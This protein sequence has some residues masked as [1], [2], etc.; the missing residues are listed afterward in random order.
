M[1][2]Q[3]PVFRVVRGVPTVEELAALV[4]AFATRSRPTMP[5]AP[6]AAS[7]WVRSGRPRTASAAALPVERGVDAWR[8][9]GRPT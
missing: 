4:G 1:S 7:T 8:L 9:S 5:P 6:P 3:E 2:S